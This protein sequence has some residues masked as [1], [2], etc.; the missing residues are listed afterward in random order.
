M[1]AFGFQIQPP[2]PRWL[3]PNSVCQWFSSGNSHTNA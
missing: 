1:S 3:A 2:L